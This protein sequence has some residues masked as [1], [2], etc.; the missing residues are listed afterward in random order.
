[1]TK[2]SNKRTTVR[3]DKK[4]EELIGQL[5]VGKYG[6]LTDLIRRLVIQEHAIQTGEALLLMMDEKTK[7][8]FA[9]ILANNKDKIDAVGVL[10]KLIGNEFVTLFDKRSTRDLMSQNNEMLRVVLRNQGVTETDI[11]NIIDR[12]NA[13]TAGTG[14]QS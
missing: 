4:T 6:E 12:A 13:L 3:L 9:Y 2:D 8:Q 11:N 1:M 10:K 5:I 14:R 7:A